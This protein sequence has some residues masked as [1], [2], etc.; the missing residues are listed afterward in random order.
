MENEPSPSLWPIRNQR[1]HVAVTRDLQALQTRLSDVEK[2]LGNLNTKLDSILSRLPCNPPGLL[3]VQ[4][5]ANDFQDINERL[6]RL[7]ALLLRTPLPD[8]QE[9]DAKIFKI[10]ST[11]E[12]T[13]VDEPEVEKTPDKCKTVGARP[14]PGASGSSKS[15]S[16]N[17]HGCCCCCCCHCCVLP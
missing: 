9:L 17:G 11:A 13:T 2:S 16:Q 6:Y 5:P 8:F 1:R 14:K 7:E 10:M 12:L 3:P 15:L 4:E